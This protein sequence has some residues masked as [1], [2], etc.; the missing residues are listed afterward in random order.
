MISSVVLEK[1]ME[2][3][4]RQPEPTMIISCFNYS[5]AEEKD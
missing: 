2:Y 5:R 1:D 3:I 4:A